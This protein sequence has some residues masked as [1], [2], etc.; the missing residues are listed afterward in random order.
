MFE[1]E[2]VQKAREFGNSYDLHE[3]MQRLGWLIN[4]IFVFSVSSLQPAAVS[5]EARAVEAPGI[6]ID[7]LGLTSRGRDFAPRAA[8]F[9]FPGVVFELSILRADE[10]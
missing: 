6:R 9:L 1:A 10:S 7:G 2:D 4:R 8:T 3:A 5:G